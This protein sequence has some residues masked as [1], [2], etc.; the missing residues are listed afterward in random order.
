MGCC[1]EPIRT[2]AIRPCSPDTL[3][4]RCNWQLP[5]STNPRKVEADLPACLRSFLHRLS[6]GA[7]EQDRAFWRHADFPDPPLS[8][9]SFEHVEEVQ[10]RDLLKASRKATGKSRT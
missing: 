6:R 5:G 2:A 1:S 10:V 9:E 3:P 8:R 7:T 4:K